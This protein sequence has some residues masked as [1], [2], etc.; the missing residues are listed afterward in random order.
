[1]QHSNWRSLCRHADGEL[2]LP[3]RRRLDEHLRVCNRCQKELN[4]VRRVDRVLGEWG[5]RREQV[6]AA[7]EGRI[8]DSVSR[9]RRMPRVFAWGKMTPAALGSSAAAL[10]V[11]ISVNFGSQYQN[12]SRIVSP[13]VSSKSPTTQVSSLTS[14][15]GETARARLKARLSGM[16]NID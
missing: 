14:R 10:L 13:T 4:L 9:P 2:T 5:Q 12:P 8:I 6:P 1:M 16:M 3:D 7:T 11:L 15:S